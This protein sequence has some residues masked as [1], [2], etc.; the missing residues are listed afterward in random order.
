MLR[1]AHFEKGTRYEDD[2]TKDETPRLKKWEE[3]TRKEL[4]NDPKDFYLF[5]L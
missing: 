4:A 1:D 3:K 2:T 5:I